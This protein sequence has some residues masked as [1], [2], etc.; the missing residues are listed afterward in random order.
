M[1]TSGTLN[2]AVLHQQLHSTLN[3]PKVGWAHRCRSGQPGTPGGQ[4]C[5]GAGAAVALRLSPLAAYL[6]PP[7][8]RYDMMPHRHL[9]LMSRIAGFNAAVPSWLACCA[10]TV[11][12]IGL[13][14]FNHGMH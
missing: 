11:G 13:L 14:S 10:L 7:S 9:T 2:V 1:R 5:G 12:N 3:E 8:V 6:R 4:Y